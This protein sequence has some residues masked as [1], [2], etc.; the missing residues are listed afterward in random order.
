MENKG[1]EIR[2]ANIKDLNEVLRLNFDLFKK[3]YKEYDKTLNLRWTH[4][5]GKKYYK[6]RI[7]HKNGFLEIALFNNTIIGYVCGVIQD[8]ELFR[9]QA[10]YAELEN[11]SIDKSFRGKG[12]GTKLVQNFLNWSKENKVNYISV[13]ASEKNKQAIGFYRNL[14]FKDHD[15]ILEMKTKYEK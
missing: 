4:T 15:L 5:E 3:E 6:N 13:K 10:K 2:R 1:L 14:G 12:I 7:I 8:R 9:I 11:M